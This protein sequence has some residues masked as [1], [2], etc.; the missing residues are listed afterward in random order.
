MTSVVRSTYVQ[1]CLANSVHTRIRW[2]ASDYFHFIELWVGW[3]R[4]KELEVVTELERKKGKKRSIVWLFLNHV[5]CLPFFWCGRSLLYHTQR[6]M[7]ASKAVVTSL[8]QSRKAAAGFGPYRKYHSFIH[9]LMHS[10]SRWSR[11]L[12]LVR[13][14]EW[15]RWK[16]SK[17]TRWSTLEPKKHFVLR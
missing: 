15:N 14:G 5:V 9:P 12:V 10:F 8:D 16:R 2:H 3:K 7:T 11:H 1:A 4:L 6:D 17:Q 13:K